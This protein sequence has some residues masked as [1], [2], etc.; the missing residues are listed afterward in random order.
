MKLFKTLF[1]AALFGALPLS[2]GAFAAETPQSSH[3]AASKQPASCCRCRCECRQND[4]DGTHKPDA[5]PENPAAAKLQADDLVSN[6][7]HVIG[8]ARPG[9][10]GCSLAQ[11][12]IACKAV[13]FAYERRIDKADVPT[14]RATLLKAWEG[15]SEAERRAFDSNF[16]DVCRLIDSCRADWP[17]MRGL[18]EDAGCAEEMEKL[19]K[20]PTALSA[21]S[22]LCAHTLTMGNSD[23]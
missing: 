12:N 11:A 7:F 8:G 6:Y 22:E 3:S 4:K 16:I 18:F 5:A 23:E 14:L 9:T 13:H 1:A 19:M 2:A 10:A 21:W 20:N 15:M 17:K